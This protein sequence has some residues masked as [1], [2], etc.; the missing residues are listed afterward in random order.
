MIYT[1]GNEKNYMAAIAENGVIQKTGKGDLPD[2]PNYPGGYAFKTAED[3]QRRIDEAY[4]DRGFAVFGLD[5]DWEADTYRNPEGGW[6][7]NLLI[8]ADIVPLQ[9]EKVHASEVE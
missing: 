7:N 6:W 1:I 9:Q 4:P 8:D 3:A 5:A 2:C